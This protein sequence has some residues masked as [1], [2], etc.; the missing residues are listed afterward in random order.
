MERHNSD[1]GVKFS[2]PDRPSV[3]Q[4]L[5]YWS[6]VMTS[7]SDRAGMYERY[8]SGARELISDWSCEHIPDIAVELDDIDDTKAAQAIMW[9]GLEVFRVVSGLEEVPKNS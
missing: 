9:A 3:R 8:W 7:G 2:L 4:Q 5:R 1:L 6:T